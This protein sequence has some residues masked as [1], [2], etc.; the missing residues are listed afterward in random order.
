MPQLAGMRDHSLAA[1]GTD[2][3]AD[4]LYDEIEDFVDNWSPGAEWMT[5]DWG[6]PQT[7]TGLA[8]TATTP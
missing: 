6:P 8:R 5:F 2:P 4:P 1:T 3:E 7:V